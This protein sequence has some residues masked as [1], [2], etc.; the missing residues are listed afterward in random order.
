VKMTIGSQAH[1]HLGHMSERKTRQ[2]AR[3]LG[4]K[5]QEGQMIPCAACAD[6]ITRQK[7]VKKF[8]VEE[9]TPDGILR[10]YLDIAT[11]KKKGDFESSNTLDNYCG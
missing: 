10:G 6:G 9:L 1:E 3:S 11:I 8:P 5:I 7:N 4:W 2:M